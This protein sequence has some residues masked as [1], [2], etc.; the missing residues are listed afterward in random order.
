[1]IEFALK[2]FILGIFTKSSIKHAYINLS[3]NQ[4]LWLLYRSFVI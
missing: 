2:F 4:P 3:G 1:V